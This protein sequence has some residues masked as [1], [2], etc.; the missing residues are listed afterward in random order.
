MTICTEKV[1]PPAAGKITDSLSVNS[2]FPVSVSRPMTLATE[3]V[4]FIEA[5]GLSVV[6]AQFIPISCIVTIETPLYRL[7]M[8]QFDVGVFLLQLPLLSVYFH[9]SMTAAAG[10]D[11]FGQGRRRNREFFGGLSDKGGQRSP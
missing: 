10:I 4:T 5:H 11:A 8:V 9:A 3:P 7:S 2:R 6:E 1:G